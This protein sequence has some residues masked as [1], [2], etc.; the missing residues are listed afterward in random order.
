MTAKNTRKEQRFASITYSLLAE[1]TGL[2]QSTIQSYGARGL[3]P[4]DNLEK[5]L[6]WVNKRRETMGWPPI[7]MP[8]P[9]QYKRTKDL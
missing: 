7:G 4:R 9:E 6:I 5:C 1:W 8:D 3:I 2:A